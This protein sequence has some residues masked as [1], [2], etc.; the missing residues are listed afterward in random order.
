MRLLVPLLLS[1]AYW[2]AFGQEPNPTF[3][4]DVNWVRVD[5]EVLKGAAAVT[6]LTE[7]DF[8]VKDNGKTVPVLKVTREEAA[9]DVVLLFDMSGSMKEGVT[10]TAASAKA[11]LA[12]LRKGDRV[13]VA[14]FND[15]FIPVLPF[16]E[17][18]SEAEQAIRFGIVAQ[19]FRGA[20][21]L[22]SS[23]M[24]SAKLLAREPLTGRRRAILVITDNQGDRGYDQDE[25]MERLWKT[26][27]VLCGLR[28]EPDRSDRKRPG[29]EK[30]AARSGCEMREALNPRQD[31][32][33]MM[34]R[35][36]NR[37]VVYYAMPEG[38]PG[39]KRE[40]EVELSKTSRQRIGE[41]RILARRGY[42][43]PGGPTE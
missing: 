22:H 19:P 15:G 2:Q 16:S 40:I 34:K 3:K 29:V 20:T 23:I 11:A 35:L 32:E 12:Q 33:E 8:A 9:L 31:F 36:R 39:E 4:A 10:E 27:T 21:Q 1:A 17:D 28:L 13:M 24:K 6:G 41:V 18:F 30:A 42:M 14:G 25:V 26:D 38:Q 37:Y 7:A 5:L 43:L